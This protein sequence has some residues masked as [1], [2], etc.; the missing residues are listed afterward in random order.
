M[1]SDLSEVVGDGAEV[2]FDPSDVVWSSSS[3]GQIRS[4]SPSEPTDLKP[5]LPLE[6][7]RQLTIPLESVSSSVV[8]P[9]SHMPEAPASPDVGFSF[10]EGDWIH[11]LSGDEL[12]PFSRFLVSVG[13]VK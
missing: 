7:H 12:E 6:V 3:L 1:P 11:R 13:R 4:S 5:I 9:Q 8:P 2:P 10:L